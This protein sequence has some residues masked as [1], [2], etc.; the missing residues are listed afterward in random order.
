MYDNPFNLSSCFHTMHNI[1]SLL[2]VMNPF[3]LSDH[4]EHSNNQNYCKEQYNDG[5]TISFVTEI[6][7]LTIEQIYKRLYFRERLIRLIHYH[8][9]QVKYLKRTNDSRNQNK[10]DGRGEYDQGLQGDSF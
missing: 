8:V 5:R 4:L 10:E 9:D 1:F 6:K 7:R 2:F 3:L